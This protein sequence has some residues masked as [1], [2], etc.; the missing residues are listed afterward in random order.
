MTGAQILARELAEI[1]RWLEPRL[2]A[3]GIAG[4]EIRAE[5]ERAQ[6]TATALGGLVGLAPTVAITAA[7]V[8]AA[9]VPNGRGGDKCPNCGET[10][11]LVPTAGFGTVSRDICGAC[12]YEPAAA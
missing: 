4:D 12:G 1:G 3:G 5:V 10:L 8:R 6:R 9:R 11:R 2:G 7:E